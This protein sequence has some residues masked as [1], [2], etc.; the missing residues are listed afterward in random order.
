MSAPSQSNQ[1]RTV[2]FSESSEL[3]LY[4]QDSSCTNEKLY[5][6]TLDK[7]YATEAAL[8]D[9]IRIRRQLKLNEMHVVPRE[10]VLGIE[11]LLFEDPRHI[12]ERRKTHCKVVL[13][14]QQL[15][16][17]YGVKDE[18]RLAHVS[19]ILTRKSTSLAITRATAKAA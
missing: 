7:K 12:I 19:A 1:R 5:Y 8:M 2:R 17:T 4:P 3:Y 6:T 14:E 11:H 10:Q 13:L 9:A 15:Q 16:N 18:R